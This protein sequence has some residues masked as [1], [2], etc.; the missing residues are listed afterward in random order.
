ME[1]ARKNRVDGLAPSVA[2]QHAGGK[3]HR[4]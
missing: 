1:A 3:D 2:G 4:R